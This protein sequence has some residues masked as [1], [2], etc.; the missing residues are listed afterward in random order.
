MAGIDT[1][2]ITYDEQEKGGFPRR[3]EKT[4]VAAVWSESGSGLTEKQVRSIRDYVAGSIAGLSRDRVTVIDQTLG[5]SYAGAGE[6]NFF[7]LNDDPYAARKRRYEEEW[8]GK[9]LETLSMVPGVVVGVNVELDPDLVH[10]RAS[11]EFDP[12]KTAAVAVKENRKTETSTGPAPSGRPGAVSN[13]VTA[14]TSA[15]VAQVEAPQSEREESGSE[16]VNSVSRNEL[17]ASKA[18]YVPTIVKASIRVPQSYFTKVWEE[19]NP[20]APGQE[21]SSPTPAQLQ[22]VEGQVKNSIEQAVVALLLE[23]EAGADPYTAVTVTTYQDLAASRPAPPS[24]AA[25]TTSWLGGNWQTLGMV[26]LGLM[27]LVMLRGAAR[28]TSISVEH[29]PLGGATVGSAPL[30]A[31][32]T[33]DEED[34]DEAEAVRA[35][36]GRFRVRGP[37]L[38]AELAEMV[39]EDPESAA[40]VLSKWIGEVN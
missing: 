33:T 19:A 9:I 27:S 16:Q 25:Q 40:K 28:S 2:S 37:N 21:P 36:A 22:A 39:R 5:V 20:P 7:D 12:K 14:N 1:A 29:T 18:A 38:R 8:R 17:R 32:A 10:D 15:A 11:V 23:Q 24:L 34:E 35:L 30:R 3:V 13:G 26:V 4:A 31:A 6:G